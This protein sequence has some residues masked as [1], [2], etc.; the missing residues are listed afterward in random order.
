MMNRI[1]GASRHCIREHAEHQR[2][3]Y[4]AQHNPTEPRSWRL[5]M[6]V[7]ERH[8]VEWRSWLPLGVS[9]W[10]RGWVGDMC[11]SATI[12]DAVTHRLTNVTDKSHQ[13]LLSQNP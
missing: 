13:L 9:S 5:L 2:A 1:R 12:N 4:I 6:G 11:E 3:Q 7:D 10:Y 8:G